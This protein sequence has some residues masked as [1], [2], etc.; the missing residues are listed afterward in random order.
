MHA[1]ISSLTLQG[2]TL[3]S[4]GDIINRLHEYPEPPAIDLPGLTPVEELRKAPNLFWKLAR[5]SSSRTNTEAKNVDSGESV[6]ETCWEAEEE[7]AEETGG[8]CE[9]AER[10]RAEETGGTCEEAERERAE[11]GTCEDAEKEWA[12]ETEGGTCEEL[13]IT[14][15]KRRRSNNRYKIKLTVKSSKSKIESTVKSRRSNIKSSGCHPIHHYDD[16]TKRRFYYCGYSGCNYSKRTR[17][18]VV[19]HIAKTHTKT[20][21]T[22]CECGYSTWSPDCWQKHQGHGCNYRSQSCPECSFKC[23]LL[24]NLNA[25]RQRIHK[26]RS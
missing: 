18:A 7:W 23:N 17:G 20:P 26:V 1:F 22:Q 6:R 11:G 14:L 16:R 12:E 4:F 24:S 2:V 3:A 21:A 5:S 9:E 10:E 15:V 19:A 8:T 25:H 13:K